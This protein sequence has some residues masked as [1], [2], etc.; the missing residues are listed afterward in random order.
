MKLYLSSYGVGNYPQRLHELLGDKVRTAIIMAAQDYQPAAMRQERL[1]ASLAELSALGLEP[2]EFDLRQYFA[3][4]STL[5]ADIAS[6]DFVWVRGGN[7]F[8]LRQALALSELDTILPRLIR[9]GAIVYGGYS[10][11]AC[12]LAP[13]LRGIDLI[14]PLDRPG[15]GY[16]PSEIIWDGLEVIDR[17][18]APHYQSDHPESADV[19]RFV[20]Y[21]EHHGMPYIALRDGE[22]YIV[23]E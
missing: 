10:A 6:Y 8:T 3:D 14:D 18:V 16:P 19:D 1:D 23:N 2:K 17:S 15:I 5:E 13:S 12:V 11:G 22:V 4:S 21:L 7:V 20:Q 9:E